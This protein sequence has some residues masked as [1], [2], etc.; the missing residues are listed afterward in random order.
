MRRK[1]SSGSRS[2]HDDDHPVREGPPDLRQPRQPHRREFGSALDDEGKGAAAVATGVRDANKRTALH[3]AAR[4]GQTEVCKF[5]IEQLRLPVD[6]K[7]DDGHI[8]IM[9][10]L[11]GK[12][13]DVE[14][15]SESGT[16]LVW[17]AGHGQQDAVKL[18][19]EH[20]AKSNT[21]TADGITSLLSAV[22]A[23]SQ[24]SHMDSVGSQTCTGWNYLDKSTCL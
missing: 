7:D 10:L 12:G 6:P 16:P 1:T 19:I 18:L 4:E 13:V 11:L 8:D 21:E 17:A 9:K 14:S 3:F 23:G 15:E 24:S 2:G 22:A 20:N 5:L